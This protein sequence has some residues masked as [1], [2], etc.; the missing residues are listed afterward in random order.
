[1]RSLCST[2]K[3]PGQR[4]PD[5]GW[6]PAVTS[7]N[8]EPVDPLT[9]PRPVCAMTHPPG[10]SPSKSSRKRPSSADAFAHESRVVRRK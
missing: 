5:G 1:M 4:P 2:V 3:V 8:D 6:G 7:E 9:N 10:R